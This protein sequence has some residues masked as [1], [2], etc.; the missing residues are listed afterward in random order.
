MPSIEILVQSLAAALGIGLLIGIVRERGHRQAVVVA[1]IRTHALLGLLGAIAALL[2]PAAMIATI[3]AV[4]ALAVASHWRTAADDPGLTSE[5]AMLAT[6]LLGALATRTP[7]VAAGLGV[8][9]AI[10]LHA[11]QPLR[12]F[13]RDLLS[14]REIDD[15]LM[16]AAAALVVMPLLPAAAIDPWGVLKLP[17]LWRIVVLVM[18]VGLAGHVAMRAI[19]PNRGLPLAG[20]FAGFASSTAAVASLG[21]RVRRDAGLLAPAASA[22]LLANLAS[23]LL[24]AFVLGTASPAQLSRLALPL[25]GAGVVLLLVAF[26]GLRTTAAGPV[27]GA[28]APSPAA[29][30]VRPMQAVMLAL[31]IG[32]VLL[33]S[34]WLRSLF[35]AT[36]VIIAAALVALAE[37][38]A[39]AASLAQLDAAGSIAATTADRAVIAI[40]AA[41]ALAK[42][43]LAG[44]SGGRAY[45]L[46][47]GAGLAAT[48]AAALLLQ[49]LLTTR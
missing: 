16:L 10:L 44:I 28:A 49:L 46:R 2:D 19:G 34:A 29:R 38:H 40:L 26:A 36:G 1:G 14:E 42:S 9:I 12:R 47:V 17:T 27:D 8:L 20:L 31:L 4:A 24:M 18:A 13:S 33:L 3:L 45:G 6:L 5:V 43:V 30:A 11:K 22:A 41:S 7:A 35:G 15:A 23:L 48:V 25:A 39:A 21:A 32:A 37:L